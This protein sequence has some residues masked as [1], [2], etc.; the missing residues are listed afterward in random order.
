[1]DAGEIDERFVFSA[2]KCWGEVV[3]VVFSAVLSSVGWYS[4]ALSSGTNV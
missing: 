3:D 1:M 4:G 2:S